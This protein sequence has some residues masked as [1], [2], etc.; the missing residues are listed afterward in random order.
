MVITSMVA[1]NAALPDIALETNATQG[2]L[3]W[4]VDGYTLVLACL[5]LPAGAIG[6]R[7]GRRVALAVAGIGK[8]FIMPATLSLLTAAFPRSERNKAVGIWAGMVSSGAVFGFLGTGILLHFWFLAVDLRGIHGR[9]SGHVHPHMHDRDVTRRNCHAG[10]LVGAVLIG[11]AVAVFVFGRLV[12][13]A[14]SGWTDP[15]CLDRDIRGHRIGGP[16]SRSFN[17]G[18]RIRCSTSGRSVDLTSRQVR[19][20]SRSCSSRISDPSLSQIGAAIGIAV[21]GSVVAAQYHHHLAP[22]VAAFPERVRGATLHSLAHAL[23]I[24]EQMDP[25]GQRLAQVANDAFLQAMDASLIILAVTP[26]AAAAFV[27]IWSPGRDGQQLR[28][29]RRLTQRAGSTRDELSGS[30]AQHDDG[31]VG[32]AAGDGRQDRP[33]DHP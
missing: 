9:R 30:V 10:R 1:L 21:V 25:Q 17:C 26:T 13:A 7:Y 29:V 28:V 18:G 15:T 22:A 27:A 4:V 32:A 14:V 31:G 3:T 6:D 11:A 33:V 8:A 12:E 23:A 19:S 24:A 16:V 5:L 20:G 2:Q